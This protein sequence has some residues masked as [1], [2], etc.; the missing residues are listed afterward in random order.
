MPHPEVVAILIDGVSVGFFH[1]LRGGEHV[2]VYPRS[3]LPDVSPLRR[4]RPAVPRPPRFVADVH[5]GT[6]ARYL[7]LLGFDT[8]YD[9]TSPDDDLAQESVGERRVLLS[10]D[11][12]LL[13]R[14]IVIHAHYV[15]AIRPLAQLEEIV[16]AFN[17][18]PKMKPFTRCMACNG[19]LRRVAASS[20]AA[21]VPPGVQRM[22]RRFARC[23]SCDKV[24]WPGTHFKRLKIIISHLG[25]V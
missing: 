22:M 23:Q 19:R 14:S 4:L 8:L 17:L 3:I 25:G 20:V 21:E 5:L 1:K 16:R 9:R 24:Y 18:A 6:L 12:G 15:R 11:V 2:E 13:K 7:R 10:R